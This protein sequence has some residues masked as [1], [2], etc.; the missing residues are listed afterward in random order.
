M[1]D[2]LAIVLDVVMIGLL[3]TGI[4]YAARLYKQLLGLRASRAEM[5]RFVTDFALTVQR[6]EAGIKGLKLAAREGGDDLE[7]LIDRSK[8]ISDELSFLVE[9]ADQLANRLSN[10]ASLAA[11]AATP[12]ARLSGEMEPPKPARADLHPKHADQGGMHPPA[13]QNIS[14]AAAARTMPPPAPP[15]ATPQTSGAATQTQQTG[16]AGAPTS[17]AKSGTES[18][19]AQTAPLSRAEAE[20]LKALEKL[21]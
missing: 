9:S 8:Q 4:V 18:K 11:R 5:E 19:P 1:G 15:N 21:G 2:L 6:A 3:I 7:K 17:T 16:T 20:L 14:G 10:T 13:S 12:E